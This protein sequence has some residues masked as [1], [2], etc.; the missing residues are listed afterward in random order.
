MEG[1]NVMKLK[2]K[3]KRKIEKE[4]HPVE[5]ID[6]IQRERENNSSNVE[7]EPNN[8][9]QGFYVEKDFVKS[10][11]KS[12]KSNAL[13]IKDMIINSDE[14][15]V[16]VECKEAIDWGFQATNNFFKEKNQ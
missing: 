12:K 14:H 1:E 5:F 2:T 3:T 6:L 8:R 13:L 7:E 15:A 11:K 10:S 16:K 9:P 4:L